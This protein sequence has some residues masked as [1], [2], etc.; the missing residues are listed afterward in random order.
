MTTRHGFTRITRTRQDRDVRSCGRVP[1]AAAKT[2]HLCR[3]DAGRAVPDNTMLMRCPASSEW[4]QA[5][6]A[7]HWSQ[8]RP[9]LTL[10]SRR[11]VININRAESAALIGCGGREEGVAVRIPRARAMQS[12]E[13]ES[14]PERRLSKTITRETA[15]GEAA[16][17]P[18]RS[19]PPT[20]RVFRVSVSRLR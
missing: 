10:A 17:F 4:P 8:Q 2:T 6:G 3:H 13:P 7:A 9:A 1:V 20:R 19:P 5:G 15:S 14:S 16:A 18:A 12:R 11:A